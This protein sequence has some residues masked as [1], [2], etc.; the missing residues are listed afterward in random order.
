MSKNLTETATF[1]TNVTVPEAGDGLAAAGAETAWQSLANR[2][3]Y[4]KTA[5]DSTVQSATIASGAITLTGSRIRYVIVD[6]ESGDPTDTLDT[7]NGGAQGQEI[8]IRSLSASKVPTVA[9]G[10]NIEL[11]GDASF[12]LDDPLDH[13][14]LVNDG[15]QWCELSRA[16]NA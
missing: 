13:L 11:V 12:A 3:Q 1:D 4:L 10:G 15:T 2:T 5:V 7:I 14:K 9:E 6:T 8:T 16:N